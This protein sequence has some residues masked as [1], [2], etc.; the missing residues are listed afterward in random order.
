MEPQVAI[1]SLMYIGNLSHWWEP[2]AR[3]QNVAAYGDPEPDVAAL[4]AAY[5]LGI[6]KNHPLVD[7]NKRVSAVVTRL[8]VRLNGHDFTAPEIS[9]L[10]TWV[11]LSAGNLEDS[12][13]T[14]WVRENIVPPKRYRPPIKLYPNSSNS[15]IIRSMTESPPCQNAGSRASRPN[16]A[17]S[18]E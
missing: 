10:Q 18:S 16:G 8:F 17:K 11:K 14:K 4:A 12:D 1:K 9:G 7:G 3:P 13:F 2:L 15:P 5:A 6:A